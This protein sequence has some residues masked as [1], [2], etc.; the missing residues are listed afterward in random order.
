MRGLLNYNIAAF[1][2]DNAYDFPDIPL[3]TSPVHC[4][5]WVDFDTY[6]TK[7]DKPQCGLHFYQA[8]YKFNSVWEYPQRYVNLFH[9]CKYVISP[10][11]SLYYDFPVAL[12]IYNKYRN[13]WLAAYYSVKGV[14]MIPNISVSTPYNYD[15]AFMG[16]PVRSVVAFSDLGCIRDKACRQ[17]MFKAYDEMIKRLEPKQVLYFTR[18][19]R[20]APSEADIIKLP[21]VK[22]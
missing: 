16:Y 12:Q 8:D 4:E 2:S 20:F 5:K 19:I 15:W 14:S 22:G 6:R 1:K 17:I 7:R 21:F 18:S 11:F 13:H 9:S 10:D 3:Y